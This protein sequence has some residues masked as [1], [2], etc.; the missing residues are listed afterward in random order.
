MKFDIARTSLSRWRACGLSLRP[1]LWLLWLGC[2]ALAHADA[3]DAPQAWSL[4]ATLSRAQEANR[5]ILSA[6]R[7]VDAARA[8]LRTV[9]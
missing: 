4:Q 3:P 8:D 6:Q 5:D 1:G 9:T 7:A 2:C